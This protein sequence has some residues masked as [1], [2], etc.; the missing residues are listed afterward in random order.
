[1]RIYFLKSL[2]LYLLQYWS[3]GVINSI[4]FT[5]TPILHYSRFRLGESGLRRYTQRISAPLVRVFGQV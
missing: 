5:S 3:G 1:M 2:A 4:F